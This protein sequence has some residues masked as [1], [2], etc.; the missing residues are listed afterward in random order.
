MFKV[1][2]INGDKKITE[3]DLFQIMQ[4]TSVKDKSKK[5]VISS[6]DDTEEKDMFLEIFAHDF[7]KIT[8]SI[9]YKRK[10]RG[11]DD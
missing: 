3:S 11:R 7:V 8:K 6:E 9:N 1:L 4:W 5:T 2:D 10:V